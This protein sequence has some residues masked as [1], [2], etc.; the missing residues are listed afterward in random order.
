MF[1]TLL[2]ILLAVLSSVED[3]DPARVSRIRTRVE[4]SG[5]RVK[6]DGDTD[7]H[8]DIIPTRT[9]SAVQV[10][11]MQYDSPKQVVHACQKMGAWP[12]WTDTQVLS[13]H[14]APGC[15]AFDPA[16]KVCTIHTLKPRFV[17]DD[18]RMA[19]QGHELEHCFLGA[20][21]HQE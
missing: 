21:H 4:V 2:L 19:N 7:D 11:L 10:V 13:G 1:K 15:N 20:Y 3:H 9:E 6:R 16:T 8:E 12:G 14:P 5:S 18:D 17:E